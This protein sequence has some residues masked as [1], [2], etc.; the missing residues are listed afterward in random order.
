MVGSR[1]EKEVPHAGLIM[2]KSDGS[3]ITAW[4]TALATH[5]E[6]KYGPVGGFITTGEL[7]NREM[8]RQSGV[9]T[10]TGLSE[11]NV[12]KMILTEITEYRKE[13]RQDKEKLFAMFSLIQQVVTTDGMER[14]M[15]LPGFEI[16]S[17]ERNPLQLYHLVRRVHSLQMHNRS[18]EDAKYMAVHRYN[19]L[20]QLAG[21]SLIEYKSAFTL[22]LGN[23]RLL[24][25]NPM[26]SEAMNAR[27]FLMH[28]D[29]ARYGEYIK[30]T[31]NEE[32]VRKD[33]FPKNMQEVVD[34][35]RMFIPTL[36]YVAESAPVVYAADTNLCYN[37]D[38]AGH[39]ARDCP[40]P[41]RE[42]RDRKKKSVK[43]QKKTD[44]IKPAVHSLAVD[45]PDE[46]DLDPFPDFFAYGLS[47]NTGSTC[48][49]DAN[50]ELRICSGE[51]SPI[52]SKHP[53]A[54]SL[55]TLA[56]CTFGWNEELFVDLRDQGFSMTGV[57]GESFGTRMG[58]MPCFGA[59]VITP[60]CKVNAI[61]M[62]DAERYPIEYIQGDRIIVR[63]SDELSLHFLYCKADKSYTCLFTDEIISALLLEESKVAAYTT[64]VAENEKAYSKTEV[65]GARAARQLMRRLFYPPDSVLVKILAG[66]SML[67]SPVTPHDVIR[68]TQIY[69]KDVASLKGRTT[70][71][72]PVKTDV[73]LV[74]KS[75]QREQHVHADI[76]YWR[77]EQFILFVVKPIMML[78][79]QWLPVNKTAEVMIAG[80]NKLLGKVR[81]RGYVVEYISTDPEKAL[82]KL[83][84][85]V[86]AVWET[87]GSRSHE[88]HVEREIRF[89]KERLR[90]TEHGLPFRVAL[91]LIRWM[92]YGC[93][94]AINAT[95]IGDNGITPREAFTGVKMDYKRDLRVAFGDYAQVSVTTGKDN[96]PAARTVAAIALCPTGNYKG[97]V[98]WMDLKT[99]R[100][101]RADRWEPLP[102]PDIIVEL[103][104]QLADRD[105]IG[106][107]RRLIPAKPNRGRSGRSDAS[108]IAP[109]VQ[110]PVAIKPPTVPDGGA[111]PEEDPVAVAS[112]VGGVDGV[113]SGVDGVDG[114]AGGVEGVAGGVDGVAGD[115]AGGGDDADAVVE[116]DVGG[117]DV[118]GDVG[119]GGVPDFAGDIPTSDD[120]VRAMC[121]SL[122]TSYPGICIHRMSVAKALRKYGELAREA[123][124]SELKQLVEKPAF[125]FV[126]KSSLTNSQRKSII[127]SS[128]FLKEKYADGKLAKLKARLVG[129]GDQQDKSLYHDISSPTASLESI[130]ITIAVGAAEDREFATCDVTGA[131]LE[132][133][134]PT[135]HQVYMSLEPAIAK[136]VVELYP[137]TEKYVCERG[138]I[139][140]RLLRALY[141]C[142]QSS[143]LWYDLLCSVLLSD[144]FVMNPYDPCVFNKLVHGEQITVCFHVD[145]LL[146]TSKSCMVIEALEKLLKKHFSEVKFARG[147]KHC[148]L[149]MNITKEDELVAVDMREYID[150][151][152]AERGTLVGA[153]SP[154]HDDL[155]EV[156]ESSPP[157]TS[158]A[159]EHFHS[160][161]AKLLYLAKRTRKDILL[162]VSHLCSR[163]SI[164]TEND[165]AKLNRVI[166]YLG[167][168]RELRTEF[169]RGED[170]N[171]TAYVDAS[172]GT[173]S[174]GTSRTG[175]VIMLAGA[176]IGAWTN[177]QKIVTKS[178]TEAELV[179]LS[180]GLPPV[181]WAREFMLSQ[182][183]AMA[184]TP[185][186]QDNQGVLAILDKGRHS[187]QRTRHMN[188]RYFFIRD[189]VRSG[190]VLLHYTATSDMVADVLTK[191]TNGIQFKKLRG[192]LLGIAC[193]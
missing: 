50:N 131:F 93:L 153:N 141:G 10:A 177:K 41:R 92:V 148:F 136:M 53:R 99:L 26:P 147:D 127:R 91:R 120:V 133:M 126:L 102:M 160:D 106:Y 116:G 110:I 121:A 58:R 79:A 27:H 11:G 97:T 139:T 158:E 176:A 180:D 118:E 154:A 28:L 125:E 105:D 75:L 98:F 39:Y 85:L 4:S 29:R 74:P 80:V 18:E 8:P 38:E 90:A 63:I 16:A 108:D 175:T 21:I 65:T 5:L 44:E 128:M 37:C 73:L 135:E 100:E 130:M 181:L 152:V 145:D 134:M 42:R 114:V 14:V 132:A 15:E 24:G 30:S 64:T 185:I 78:L 162:A 95:R 32:L 94:S 52:S 129:G 20:K 138:S 81:S 83:D 43:S 87:V 68:A 184:A 59:A 82:A 76:F 166:G 174:D 183:Y 13:V 71:G 109:L 137:E 170:V 34:G 156:L 47:V 101:L 86:D 187:K 107:R 159:K 67:N 89:V 122:G 61:A 69:G 167:R 157:L 111:F 188:I 171:L 189:R 168:S 33:S 112:G 140:V 56:N 49:Y 77:G 179:A 165:L 46:E 163:V 12:S 36:R 191:P 103:L 62:A 178:S 142:V 192:L 96:G 161:V 119:G 22:A 3:N 143:K 155:F 172:F 190:E 35:A 40:Q 151:C 124:V 146:I 169:K 193:Y 51:K 66:G 23:M 45:T 70:Y 1:G 150:S 72:G 144:D 9:S 123:S 2:L 7:Y 149:A 182:G 173:H 48:L 19:A 113:A 84:G 115:V 31:L 186:A 57:G 17:K 88:E 54:V 164:P 6:A 55:D 60:K 104:N 25:V 117:V